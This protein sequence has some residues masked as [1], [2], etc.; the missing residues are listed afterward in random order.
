MFYTTAGKFVAI[1]VT[2]L[3]LN[4]MLMTIL[5][6]PVCE[7]NNLV[8]NLSNKLLGADV[9]SILQLVFHLKEVKRTLDPIIQLLQAL[10]PILH[11]VSNVLGILE[12]LKIL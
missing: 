11:S 6:V 9:N 3:A 10:I 7:A 12:R 8:S 4:L 1:A 5:N 2:V